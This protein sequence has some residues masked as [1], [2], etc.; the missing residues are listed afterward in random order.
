MGRGW[1]RPVRI[2]GQ[3]VGKLGG[4]GRVNDKIYQ[5]IL[6]G[7]I[8]KWSVQGKKRGTFRGTGLSVQTLGERDGRIGRPQEGNVESNR[9][10]RSDSE[11]RDCLGEKGEK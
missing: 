1:K 9:S 3:S 10:E 2:V 7:R 5:I 6:V 4:G 8:E 11:V